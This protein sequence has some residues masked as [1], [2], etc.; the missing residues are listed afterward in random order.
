MISLE[1]SSSIYIERKLKNFFLQN[2]IFTK[3]QGPAMILNHKGHIVAMNQELVDFLNDKPG[4]IFSSFI[5]S[6]EKHV[7][8]QMKYYLKCAI[9][10]EKQN[11]CTV[12]KKRNGT[13]IHVEVEYTPIKIYDDTCALATVRKS[14][15]QDDLLTELNH[16]FNS[17]QNFCHFGFIEYDFLTKQYSLSGNIFEIFEI[18]KLNQK[19][20]TFDYSFFLPFIHPDDRPDFEKGYLKLVQLGKIFE[21]TFR[22]ILPEQNIKIIYIQVV[23]KQFLDGKPSKLIGFLIDLTEKY[24]MQDKLKEMSKRLSSV[25][26]HLNVY[27]WSYDVVNRKVLYCSEGVKKIYGV[28]V[29]FLKSEP[30][31]WKMCI[32]PNDI[33]RVERNQE[34]LKKG[35][36]L[37]HEYRII[38]TDGE[39]IWVKDHTVPTLNEKGEIV[40]L[41]GIIVDITKIKQYEEQIEKIAYYDVLTSLPNGNRLSQDLPKWTK[42]VEETDEIFAVFSFDID[43]IKKINH[44][45]GYAVGDEVIKKLAKRL[46]QVIPNHSLIYRLGGDEFVVLVNLGSKKTLYIQLAEDI[47]EHVQKPFEINGQEIFL[48]TSIGICF[49]PSEGITAKTLLPSANAALERA[50]ILG[51]NNY[52]IYSSNMDIMSFKDYYLE[53]DLRKAIANNELYIEYQPRVNV[54]TKEIVGAE[55]LLRWKHPELGNVSPAEFIPIAEEDELI[56]DLTHFVVHEVCQQIHNWLNKGIQFDS[57]SINVSPKRLLKKGFYDYLLETIDTLGV[58]PSLLEIELTETF[59]LQVEDTIYEQLNLLKQLGVK[60]ALDDFGTGYTSI[61]HLKW[62]PID[63]VKLDKSYIHK[64]EENEHNRVIT[65]SIVDLAK[66]L[67]I[68]VVAEGVETHDQLSYL[69]NSQCDEI[70]GF[71]FSP[72]VSIHQIEQFF[73]QKKLTPLDN[74]YNPSI[75]RRKTFRFQLPRPLI[76]NITI[77]TIKGKSIEIGKSDVLILNFGGGG[78]CFMTHLS[79]PNHEHILYQLETSILNRS[80]KVK[81]KVI[82]KKEIMP[83]IFKYGLKFMF[84]DLEKEKFFNCMEEI[85]EILTNDHIKEEKNFVHE[86]PTQYLEELFRLNK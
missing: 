39:I 47:L 78:L 31:Y 10:G 15:H 41:D 75:E 23:P 50:K 60:I 20:Q 56:I 5:H 54:Q 64:L 8:N 3:S 71:L 36:I 65:K 11:F 83:N 24:E 70:Q 53:R 59:L 26:D 74:E 86:A 85:K 52:Q 45:F 69:E 73:L 62:F 68:K 14:P 17:P 82:W 29:E 57:I 7:L 27:I 48:T 40:R 1:D 19:K 42:K 13:T 34:I 58:P 76:S 6:I 9:K 18:D 63:V 38:R 51:K 81:G 77:S 72:A 61:N 67:G 55:A 66:G 46:K 44:A 30:N 25:T 32:H 21:S 35:E 79:L 12:W 28:D 37:H 43:R 22:I 49:Y 16:Y 4:D 84:S 2:P 80:I 33:N